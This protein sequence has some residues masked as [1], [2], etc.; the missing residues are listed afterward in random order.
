MRVYVD[1]SS[2]LSSGLLIR[3]PSYLHTMSSYLRTGPDPQAENDAIDFDAIDWDAVDFG[4][5]DF[6]AM[7]SDVVEFFHHRF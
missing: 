4:A 5:P 3:M 1:F 2:R 7:H 6:D